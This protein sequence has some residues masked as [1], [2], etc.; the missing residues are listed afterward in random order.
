VGDATGCAT[1]VIK[2]DGIVPF[3]CTAGSAGGTTTQSLTVKRDASPPVLSIGGIAAKSYTPLNAPKRSAVRCNASDPTSGIT[4]CALSGFSK[5]RG[6]HKL[7]A[8]A[9]D[10]AA[11]T[12]TKSLTY[13]VAP[14]AGISIAKSIK[15]SKLISSGLP[16]ALSVDKGTTLGIKVTATSTTAAAA[17]STVVATFSK[18]I[19]KGGKVKVR[20]K[21]SRSGRAL[22]SH[23]KKATLRVKVTGSSKGAGKTSTTQTVK[24][25]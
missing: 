8:S 17:R 1:T 22:L 16:V 13:K 9:T 14:I 11:L 18:K 3:T 20:V 4:S 21:L 23:S 6:S 12:S 2:T 5:G 24:A 19:K 25:K 7:T 10:G 15:L